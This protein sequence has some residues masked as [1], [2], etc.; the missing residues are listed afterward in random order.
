MAAV[1]ADTGGAGVLL[2]GAMGV[3]KTRLAQDALAAAKEAGHE[4]LWV[5]AT[6]SAASIPFGAVSHLLPGGEDFGGDLLGV[7]RRVAADIAARSAHTPVVLAVDD[8]HLLDDASAALIH[9]LATQGLALVVVTVRH[10]EPA[11]DAITALGGQER[12]HRLGV[13]VLPPQA[14]DAIIDHALGV[15][16]DGITRHEI[17]RLAEG[18]P[19]FL[20]ELLREGVATGALRRR[21][22][23]WRW[24]G[25]LHDSLPLADLLAGRLGAVDA[26]VLSVLEVVACGEPLPVGLLDTVADS[27]VLTEAWR[28]GLLVFDE[29]GQRSTVRLAHPLYAELVRATLPPTRA[30]AAWGRLAAAVMA[31]PMRR[32]DDTLLAGV[33]QVRSGTVTHPDV[34]LPA[35]RQ[36]LVRFDLALA[37]QLARRACE[38]GAGAEAE[39]TLAEVLELRGRQDTG[40]GDGPRSS[41]RATILYWGLGADTSVPRAG[42]AAPTGIERGTGSEHPDRSA[43]AATVATRS[44]L[45]LF[46]GRCRDALATGDAVLDIDGADGE[47]VVRAA[48]AVTASAGLLGRFDHA[49]AARGRAQRVLAQPAGAELPWAREQVGYSTCL[50]L[51]AGGRLDE[52]WRTADHG[53]QSAVADRSPIAAGCWL[54]FRGVAEK[55]QGRVITA[56]RS[57]QESVALLQDED[58]YQIRPAC[59]AKLASSAALVGDAEHAHQWIARADEESQ[60][61]SPLFAA[62]IEQDRAW[63]LAARGRT[64]DAV[65]QA[66][67]AARLAQQSEQPTHE[68]MALYDAARLGAPRRVQARLEELATEIEGGLAAALAAAATALGSDDG[69]AMEQA[70]TRFDDLGM[71]LLSAELAAASARAYWASG[72]TARATAAQRRAA[73]LASAC[74]GADTPLLDLRELGE[75]LTTR[76]REVVLLAASGQPGREIAERLGLSIR[77]VNNYLGRAYSKLGVT[78]RRELA[79][80]FGGAR[81]DPAERGTSD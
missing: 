72:L 33:W 64:P 51:V 35:A 78:G 57:L 59:L 79:D 48:A 23:V 36:A 41:T 80:L 55:T 28:S 25:G 16:V 21:E 42:D 7:L 20:R 75:P 10:G 54:A 1:L 11:P 52:A 40:P 62:W 47:A 24:S 32:R 6:R 29:S 34:L 50:A 44:L 31:T 45:L 67:R 18:N 70:A 56:R 81:P 19:L 68:A 14:V 58:P 13:R 2:T 8:A 73:I 30:R 4:V 38:V 9:H 46:E 37:E 3:G 60:K 26:E 74:E 63:V 43:D 61:A 65:A 53:Y 27:T 49:M 66:E 76:E 17:R 12:I 15:P 69:A 77:T 5:A 71:P 22:G 39:R